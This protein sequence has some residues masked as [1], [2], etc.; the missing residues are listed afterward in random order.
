MDVRAAN[1]LLAVAFPF[2]LVFDAQLR[3][4]RAGRGIERICPQAAPGV[5]LQQV[6]R[7]LRPKGLKDHAAILAR[8]TQLFVLQLVHNGLQLRGQIVPLADGP[9]AGCLAFIGSPWVVDLKSL[10]GLGLTLADFAIHDPVTEFVL[11]LQ[12]RDMALDD[13]QVLARKLE[14]ERAELRE[15]A[16]LQSV[17][18]EVSEALA[19]AEDE[20]VAGQA[21]L[22]AICGGLEFELGELWLDERGG[23]A[24][25]RVQSCNTRRDAKVERFLELSQGLRLARGESIVGRVLEH[26]DPVW[27]EDC[28]RDPGFV[29]AGSALEAGLRTALAVPVAS[30]GRIHGV[31]LL[32]YSSVCAH[33]HRT[34]EGIAQM[35]E[36]LGWFIERSRGME[37]VRRAKEDAEEANRA[38]SAF[39]ASMSHEIRTPL[40]AVIGMGGL[41]L[42]TKLTGEQRELVE[43]MRN[44]GD[45]L[46]A[47]INDILDLSKIESGRIELE[48]R[49]TDVRAV[50]EE[51]LDVVALRAV[52]KGLRVAAVVDEDVPDEVVTDP[53]R[54]RQV[55][56]NLVGNAV[57]FTEH[58][59]V[60]VELRAPAPGRLEFSVKD[61][62]IGIPRERRD[63]LFQSFSQVDA[64][65]TRRYGG[66]GLGLAISKQLVALLGGSIRVEG[67]EGR[68]S[69]FAFDIQAPAGSTLRRD[70]RDGLA[71]CRA[72]VLEPHRA[73]A[74]GLRRML[75]RLGL[76]VDLAPDRAAAAA[77]LAAVAYDFVLCDNAALSGDEACSTLLGRSGAKL[78]ALHALGARVEAPCA[79]AR[80]STPVRGTALESVLRDL[81]ESGPRA[82]LPAARDEDAS[83]LGELRVLLAEDNP[84]NRKVA[85]RM[86][87]KLGLHADTVETGRQAV[88]ALEHAVYDVVLMDVQMPEMDGLEA[89]RRIRA[90]SGI[91]QPHIVA[92]TAN[93]VEGDRNACLEAGMN[94]YVSKPVRLEL[95]ERAIRLVPRPVRQPNLL[96]GASGEGAGRGCSAGGSDPRGCASGGSECGGNLLASR[97]L[98]APDSARPEL[99]TGPA[100]P[101]PTSS[102]E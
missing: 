58:G 50:I 15:V 71:G 41:L 88:E 16:A 99:G 23:G 37:A 39:L 51:A 101:S 70:G 18:I 80:L 64:S 2:H 25:R 68:G 8:S 55:L 86:L 74:E 91:H 77:L 52:E 7:V 61:T 81:R 43:I 82:P 20:R 45:A 35:G 19:H 62:G 1:D 11:L 75:A 57:K 66:T 17:Q 67:E 94:D 54:L 9:E 95:L 34:I 100:D 73:T 78:V 32:F 26:G 98:Q 22:D 40:N 21:L 87:Q 24:A 13:A 3:I 85:Q 83:P 90:L 69:T 59:E 4:V 49:E 89:T 76:Q 93:A 53:L 42:G 28:S 29:R 36:R 31:L 63:R 10:E 33:S 38:K 84:I 30:S 46:L 14:K 5:E 6:A 44:S 48:R 65:T 27:S 12:T 96:G 92:M 72:L 79:A 97:A 56:V 102:T 47:I 60:V